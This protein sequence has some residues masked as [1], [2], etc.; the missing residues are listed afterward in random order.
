MVTTTVA[1]SSRALA[2]QAGVALVQ[3][4]HCR[5]EPERTCGASRR[6]PRPQVGDRFD[7]SNAM[8]RY[9]LG[10]PEIFDSDCG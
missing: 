10:T 6:D 7:D 3:R 1:H 5:D 9:R 8:R 2:N 4:A